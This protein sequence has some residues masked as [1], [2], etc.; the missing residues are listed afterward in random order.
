MDFEHVGRVFVLAVLA[1]ML[2]AQA[3]CTAPAQKEPDTAPAVAAEQPPV[4]RNVKAVRLLI[5]EDYEDCRRLQLDSIGALAEA[6]LK[7]ANLTPIRGDQGQADATLTIAIKG[8]LSQ[9]REQGSGRVTYTAD[10]GG[11]VT[12]SAPGATFSRPVTNATHIHHAFFG[13]PKEHAPSAYKEALGES[14]LAQALGDAICLLGADR[15]RLLVAALEFDNYGARERNIRV[16][17][18]TGAPA[19]EPLIAALNH[20]DYVV[21]SAAAEALGNIGDPRAAEPLIAALGNERLSYAAV[22]ALGKL[23]DRR[24]VE[25]LLRAL[26]S[27]APDFDKRLAARALGHI[28]DPAAVKPLVEG[29]AGADREFQ[30]VAAEAIDAYLSEPDGLKQATADLSLGYAHVREFADSYGS[31]VPPSEEELK[32]LMAE[33]AAQAEAVQSAVA[34][35]F[36]TALADGKD[37]PRTA[38]M[39][40][41][42]DYATDFEWD[43]VDA[44]KVGRA[45]V[46]PLIAALKAE[47]PAVR[48]G[49]AV[50]LGKIG[51]PAAVEAVIP[52]LRDRD[53][54]VRVRAAHALADLHDPRACKPLI[55]ALRRM[56]I[57]PEVQGSRCGLQPDPEWKPA[58]HAAW[59]L[60]KLKAGEAVEPLIRALERGD[61]Y[62]KAYVAEAL[63]RIGDPRAIQPLIALFR[64]DGGAWGCA[65]A[66]ASHALARLGAPAVGPLIEA[67]KDES[68]DINASIALQG[69]GEPAVEPLMQVFRSGGEKARHMAGMTLA[70]IKSP[71]VLPWLA[72]MLKDGNKE[73]RSAAIG[74]LRNTKDPGI[75]E[76]LLAVVENRQEDEE[77]RSEALCALVSAPD[78]RAIAPVARILLKETSE[79]LV[80]NA[81]WVLAKMPGREPAQV[82]FTCL[83]SNKDPMR[84]SAAAHGLGCVEDHRAAPLLLAALRDADADVRM[85]A[86]DSLGQRCAPET[87]VVLREL[88]QKDP[89]PYMRDAAAKAVKQIE[90]RDR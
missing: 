14:N 88:A 56:R 66:A 22:S 51:D 86:A 55:A 71:R 78:Q 32:P 27:K 62:Y 24:A 5:E 34:A 42:L 89:D 68:I 53:A 69:I 46:A 20:G 36:R 45:A 87:L 28:P 84:R 21:R 83:K 80:M 17:V 26:K 39:F 23:R 61:G 52:L 35:A 81:G 19:V 11:A 57:P 48:A 12:L 7:A 25:P 58:S 85:N 73:L 47:D 16:L 30:S 74:A 43:R 9:E 13:E 76:P 18:R 3:G 8:T 44:R 63:G 29:L 90:E 1:L 49:A 38:L 75:I 72:R 37:M 41:A 60:G 67:L 31:S 40:G 54:G 59:A 6:L 64:G 50:A 79:I 65:D 4:F 2:V 10:L 15:N 77:I 82:L 33:A 70:D